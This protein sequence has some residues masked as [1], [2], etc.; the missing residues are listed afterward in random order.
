MDTLRDFPAL[1]GSLREYYSTGTTKEASW[2]KSQLN[3]LLNFLKER[4][5]DIV[6]ALYQDLGKHHAEAFRD[7]VFFFIYF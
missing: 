1:L 5:R 3:G 6:N 7:E 4:E 2:R